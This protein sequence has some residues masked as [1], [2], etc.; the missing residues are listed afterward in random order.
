VAASK[1][2]AL[3][4]VNTKYTGRHPQ[5]ALEAATLPSY[6][7]KFDRLL[8][9]N[10]DKLPASR[11]LGAMFSN[12]Y[13]TQIRH[14]MPTDFSSPEM[15]LRKIPEHHLTYL[16]TANPYKTIMKASKRSN[17][18]THTIPKSNARC[19]HILRIRTGNER[20]IFHLTEGGKLLN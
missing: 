10:H 1:P 19:Q 18:Q 14:L 20:L 6:K 11:Y 5:A 12:A 2:K 17:I 16:M 9:I 7:I 4:M 15:P 3:G 13:S 8:I